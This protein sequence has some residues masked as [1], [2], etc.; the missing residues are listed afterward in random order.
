MRR[1]D[2]LA[3]AAAAATV[4]PHRRPR[5]AVDGAA[6]REAVALG[7]RRGGSGVI[8]QAGV[9]LAAWGSQTARYDLKS[10]TK[11]FGSL[12]L[13][14]AIGDGRVALGG[15]AQSYLPPLGVPPSGNAGTGWLD[16]ITLQ[17][18]ATHTAGF[19]KRGGFERLLFRPGTAWSYSDGGANWLADVLTLRFRQ[20]LAAVL[21]ARILGPIGAAG[22]VSW[23]SNAYR[24]ATLDGI[25]RREFGSGISASVDAMAR[26]GLLLLDGGRGIVP[27][28]YVDAARR[29]IPAVAALRQTGTTVHP[30]ANRHYGLL[31]WNNGDGAMAGVPRDAFWAWGLGD[32]FIL[33]VPSKRLVA[34]RAG[35]TWS[36]GVTT[37]GS[38]RPLQPFFAAVCAAVS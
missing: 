27:A 30:G 17:H 31:F 18:L 23:R 12:L 36:P 35:P 37:I 16:E 28:G 3:A 32:S 11:S 14:L 10:S 26:V 6:L 9:R 4:L 38:L 25:P 1:R 5:A 29:P 33:V 22:G 2:L 13:G 15:R 34:A 21:R 19:D 8:H 7:S 24:P 20:D